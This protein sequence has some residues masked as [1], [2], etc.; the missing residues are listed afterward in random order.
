MRQR[1][2]RDARNIVMTSESQAVL[3]SW[4]APPGVN[5]ALILASVIYLRGWLR[6]HR[7]FPKLISAG[8]LAAF[9]AGIISMW[10][11]VGSPLEAFDELSLS[12]HMVQ[13]LLLMAIAPPLILLGAPALPLLQGL[14]QSIARSVV[15]P[16][17]RW[18]WVKRFGRLITNPAICWLAATIALIGWHIPAVFELALR[19]QW[20]HKLE[21][22]SFFAAGIL[23]WWPVVQPWPSTARWPRWSIPLYL[24]FV[25]LP[26]DALS[27]FLAFCDRVVYSSYLSAPR[28]SNVSPL[29]D[30]EC[31][32]ALMW[33]CVTI[34][35]L[36]PAVVV[37]M[38]ILSPPK[39]HP[40]LVSFREFP[41][42]ASHSI[43]ASKPEVI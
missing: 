8:R 29:Q 7:D 4:S 24:F 33:V 6:L 39:M 43:D 21:H 11:A 14:P 34:I 31:A 16:I 41:A 40:P 32:A 36:I 23:F 3:Q 30:Q 26:C 25:T 1:R 42:S 20:L 10:I 12:V 17:L 37:T 18:G 19:W 38:H 27:A 2:V 9:L 35:F 5:L 22:A 28:L 15:G 13:H